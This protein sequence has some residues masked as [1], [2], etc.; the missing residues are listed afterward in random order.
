MCGCPTLTGFA[1]ATLEA[2]LIPITYGLRRALLLVSLKLSSHAPIL[3][4]C[5]VFHSYILRSLASNMTGRL[6][7]KEPM[8]YRVLHFSMPNA[9]C[10]HVPTSGCHSRFGRLSQLAK[11]AWNMQM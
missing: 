7:K 5:T 2:S 3:N 8:V 1:E 4:V 10:I 6:P 11:F 9:I